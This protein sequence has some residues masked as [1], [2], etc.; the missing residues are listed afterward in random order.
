MEEKKIKRVLEI[1]PAF[2]SWLV[3]ITFVVSFAFWPRGAV[4]LLMVYLIYWT[5]RLFYMSILLVIAHL[6]MRRKRD[7]DW[8]KIIRSLKSSLQ[9]DEVMHAV[10]YPVYREPASLIVES[11]QALAGVNYPKNK[12]MVILAGEERERGVEEKLGRIKNK[13]K[14]IFFDI[15]I[16]VHPKDLEGEIPA[17]GANSTYAA[18]KLVEYL[19][20]K[21]IALEKVVVSCF[22]ADTRPHQNY[23]A[24]LTYHFLTYPKRYQASFQP[25]PVYSNNIYKVPA[26]ARI[27]EM[28]STFWQLV[29]S[30]RYEKFVTFSSHAISLKTLVEVD[31]WPVDLISDDSLIFW[32]CFLKFRGD[33]R[34]LALDV[35]VYMDI[36]AGKNLWETLKIQYLQKR[37]WAQGVENFVFLG[38]NF[39]K[40]KELPL[41]LKIS[42]LYQLLDNNVN[43]ATWAIVISI[44][45]P[46]IITAG[47]LTMKDS[48]VLF[49]LSYINNII[50][51]ALV[52]VI[53]LSILI[54]WE[55]LPLRPLHL[56]RLIYISFIL[57]WLLIP[58]VS[59]LLGSLPALDAQTR[60][61]LGRNVS[62]YYTPKGRYKEGKREKVD[63]TL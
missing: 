15:I 63:L 56:S 42:K 10:L 22:D 50:S 12:I 52:F 29:E 1:I 35:P 23:F 33:Y 9:W 6:R 39:W 44:I 14:D 30:M 26:L 24:N 34:T 13:F 62:F 16:T 20:E 47:N 36:A 4:I 18:K 46:F 60:L 51:H 31:F 43:W 41:S 40:D 19:R 61:M 57:Q 49:N 53:V 7:W 48:L 28:G 3:I 25:I 11:L 45:S 55:F 2:F 17:K 37:R 5:L 32:K 27:I 8:E 21:K 54:S 38:I 59:A 58:L